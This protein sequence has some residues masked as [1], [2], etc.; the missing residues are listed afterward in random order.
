MPRWRLL[1]R[2]LALVAALSASGCYAPPAPD[3]YYAPTRTSV[4]WDGLPPLSAIVPAANLVRDRAVTLCPRLSYFWAPDI[5]F[6]VEPFTCAGSYE[7]VNG[8]QPLYY[9]GDLMTVQIG[10]VTPISQTALCDELLHSAWEVCFGGPGE[11][12][13]GGGLYYLPG[14]DEAVGACRAAMV[15]LDNPDGGP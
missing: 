3:L 5:W 6:E 15:A 9:Y 4:Y 1:V 8:C 7:V 12:N 13:D 11:A 10:W 2:A 14:F